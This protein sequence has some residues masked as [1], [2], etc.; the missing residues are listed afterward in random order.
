MHPLTHALHHT[1]TARPNRIGT[2]AGGRDFYGIEISDKP[3]VDES[4]PNVKYIANMHGDE[5]SGR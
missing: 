5:I 4:E 2:S 1:R 3:G